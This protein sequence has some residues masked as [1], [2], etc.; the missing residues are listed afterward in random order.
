M[1][2]HLLLVAASALLLPRAAAVGSL[3]DGV[4]LAGSLLPADTEGF[5]LSSP[6]YTAGPFSCAA[7]V[8][9][10]CVSAGT[11]PH[12]C[13]DAAPLSRGGQDGYDRLVR[14]Y[15]CVAADAADGAALPSCTGPGTRPPL[16]CLESSPGAARLAGTVQ[17]Q[18]PGA[19]TSRLGS[20]PVFCSCFVRVDL[21]GQDVHGKGPRVHS[22]SEDH[23]PLDKV[24]P[25]TPRVYSGHADQYFLDGDYRD[26][27]EAVEPS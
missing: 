25:T 19:D 12:E 20:T 18:L 8:R 6:P 22:L 2:A 15:A 21:T 16:L 11:A 14:R 17:V 9:A 4:L 23:F 5:D 7:L 27:G 10:R 24:Y 3:R 26:P 13:A 1:F